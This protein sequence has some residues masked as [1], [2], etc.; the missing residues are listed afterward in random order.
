VNI[1]QS[2]IETIVDENGEVKQRRTN[3][4]LSYPSEPSFIKLYIDD[5]IYLSDMPKSYSPILYQFL[6]RMTY[7]GEKEG[8]V[9]FVNSSMKKRIQKE[10]GYKNLS[11]INNAITD[12]V[13]AKV[14]IRLDPST[15]L[16]NPYL[17][18]KGDW[19]DISKLRLEINYDEIKGRTFK[20]ICEY[21]NQEPLKLAR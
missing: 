21:K 15:Y 17:F 5:V 4:T 7:A 18:G 19:Q 9:V 11:S 8:Q 6:K 1:K 10:L 12:F 2:V 3:E 14:F 16:I 13:K 20:S